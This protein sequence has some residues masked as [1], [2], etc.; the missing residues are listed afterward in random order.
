[1]IDTK[2]KLQPISDEAWIV[3]RGDKRIG[4]LNKN[5]HIPYFR[6]ENYTFVVPQRFAL[7]RGG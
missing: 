4:L 2:A 3:Q 7:F 5:V 1:M 6:C